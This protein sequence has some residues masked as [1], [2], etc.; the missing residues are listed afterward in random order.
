M[1]I[2]EE[3]RNVER[4]KNTV[5]VAYGKNKDKYAVRS[6]LGCKSVNG[7]KIPVDGPVI[8][9]IVDLTYVPDDPIAPISRSDT[10]YLRWA[11]IMLA[12]N[13]SK[14]ILE[15]L[16]AVYNQS[17]SLKTYCMAIIRA[18][19]PD[20][21]DYDMSCEYNDCWL[22]QLY[23]DVPLSKN[24]VGAHVSDLGRTVSRIDSFMRL[25][26]SRVGA[27]AV[28][29]V[30]GT[31]K[32]NE[33][34]VNT[35]SDFSRKARTKGTKDIS[36][37]YCFDARSGE[38]IC[39]RAYPGN[40]IDLNLLDDFITT[41]DLKRGMIVADKGFSFNAAKKAFLDR[42]DLHF[43]FP[44]KRDSR[45]LKEY[46]MFDLDSSLKEY[47]GIGCRKE[48]MTDG[49]FLY[50]FRDAFKASAEESNWLRD[51]DDYNPLE[52]A[53][54]RKE[55]GTVTF[56]SDVD[57]DYIDAYR[58]YEKRW[59]IETM[60]KFYKGVLE[61]DETRVH[62]DF[63]VMGTE[64]VNFLSIIIAY[65]LAST[66]SKVEA[67]ARKPYKAAIRRLRRA[68]MIRGSDGEWHLRKITEKEVGVLAELGLIPRKIDVKRP[69]GRP[70]IVR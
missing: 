40:C 37:L 57:M 53:E 5:V 51:K 44:L 33:S 28:L 31:L 11:D 47:D 68:T 43:L 12:V 67:L 69:R 61:F 1:G 32:S 3:I 23:P 10:D 46:R 21:K 60:F 42:P 56:V 62:E 20:V 58:A 50:S 38:P 16:R 41:N 9:H 14:D 18:L 59:E 70:K 17:D 45:V 25:R 22:S 65:R 54:L 34:E 26:T 55:L 39:S 6:R 36:V 30:D 49:L 66:F 35:F 13:Q 8:G 2:P 24:T 48:R 29:A 4:P 64:F 19:E 7:R 27:D 63:S 15:D 52:L